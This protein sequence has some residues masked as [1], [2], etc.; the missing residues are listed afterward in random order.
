LDEEDRKFGA[1]TSLAILISSWVLSALPFVWNKGK[2][3]FSLFEVK[4]TDYALFAT[5]LMWYSPFFAEL[6]V[7]LNWQLQGVFGEKIG[8]LVLGGAGLNDTL[9]ILGFAT[10]VSSGLYAIIM[11]YTKEL[12]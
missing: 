7:L 6:L 2:T 8:N 3:A 4:A 9:F 1:F 12:T 10:L 5:S 11:K